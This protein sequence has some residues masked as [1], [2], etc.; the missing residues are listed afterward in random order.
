M[1]IEFQQLYTAI[2]NALR[3]G[4][5]VG[6]VSLERLDGFECNLHQIDRH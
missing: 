5:T 6:A 4:H 3:Y 2:A 1:S